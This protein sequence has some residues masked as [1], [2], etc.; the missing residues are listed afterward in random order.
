MTIG[1]V[2]AGLPHGPSVVLIHG[3]GG[4]HHTW[5]RVIALIASQ[6][7]VLALNAAGSDPIEREA[8]EA[9]E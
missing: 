9:A 6:A 8:D 3:L 5:D 4:S 7:S 2:A 1:A